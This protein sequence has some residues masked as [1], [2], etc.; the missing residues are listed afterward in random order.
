MRVRTG[1]I[2]YLATVLLSV[3]VTIRLMAN[4]H[5]SDRCE[6]SDS[7]AAAGRPREGR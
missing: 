6:D 2:R 7:L 5:G 3:V 4:P 1:A